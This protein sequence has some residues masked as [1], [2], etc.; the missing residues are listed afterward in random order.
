MY[1][2]NPYLALED[3]NFFSVDDIKDLC[4]TLDVP[5][6]QDKEPVTVNV[7]EHSGNENCYPLGASSSAVITRGGSNSTASDSIDGSHSSL[8]LCNGTNHVGPVVFS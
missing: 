6:E 4:F 3:P 1:V 8:P 7:L 2:I 5:C